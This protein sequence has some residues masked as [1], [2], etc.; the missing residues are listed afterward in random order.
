M[1]HSQS[2]ASAFRDMTEIQTS[3]ESQKDLISHRDGITGEKIKQ[4]EELIG[5]YSSQRDN[6]NGQ[7]LDYICLS[8]EFI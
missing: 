8:M 5:S 7:T 3:S 2:I 4:I 1:K 6:R